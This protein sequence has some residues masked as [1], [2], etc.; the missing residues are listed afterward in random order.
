MGVIAKRWRPTVATTR[1][2]GCILELQDIHNSCD[3]TCLDPGE[4]HLSGS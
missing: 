4:S 1:R 3:L 2:Q